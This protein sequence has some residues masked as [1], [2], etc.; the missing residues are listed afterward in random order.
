MRKY[1]L[2]LIRDTI[3]VDKDRLSKLLQEAD[4]ISRVIAVIILSV[5]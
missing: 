1:W 4:E 2:C 3:E 5:K